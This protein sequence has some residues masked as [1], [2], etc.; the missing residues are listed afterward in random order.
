MSFVINQDFCSACHR[1]RTECPKGAIR[2]RNAKNWIDP[3][4]C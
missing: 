3:G 4:K 1:C 2:F